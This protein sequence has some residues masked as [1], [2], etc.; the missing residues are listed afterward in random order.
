MSHAILLNWSATGS[1]RTTL[2]RWPRL[3]NHKIGIELRITLEIV[4]RHPTIKRKLIKPPGTGESPKTTSSRCLLNSDTMLKSNYEQRLAQ[5]ILTRQVNV[6]LVFWR[7]LYDGEE[8]ALI[9]MCKSVNL[10][11]TLMSNPSFLWGFCRRITLYCTKTK[12]LIFK[13]KYK[14]CNTK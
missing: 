7:P 8:K 11:P 1:A 10:D 9:Y 5:N 13:T 4:K 3:P 6:K 2:G 12:M 14:L